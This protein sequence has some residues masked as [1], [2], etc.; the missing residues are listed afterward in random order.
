MRILWWNGFAYL[1]M[2]FVGLLFPRHENMVSNITFPAQLG[3]VASMLWLVIK[4]AA[5]QERDAAALS[6]SAP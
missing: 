4:G 6:S 1:T 3:E 5:P 2:N